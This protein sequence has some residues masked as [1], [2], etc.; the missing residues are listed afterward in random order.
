MKCKLVLSSY[1]EM[2]SPR[3]KGHQDTQR[4]LLLHNKKVHPS[5]K[6]RE[7]IVYKHSHLRVSLRHMGMALLYKDLFHHKKAFTKTPRLS[8]QMALQ[9]C[10]ELFHKVANL[11]RLQNH[12]YSHHNTPGGKK[13]H[14]HCH[15]IAEARIRSAPTPGWDGPTDCPMDGLHVVD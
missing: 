12:P 8:L 2:L 9:Y 11:Q 13:C 7:S 1:C 10:I 3:H 5:C 15:T 4:A 6:V 14:M